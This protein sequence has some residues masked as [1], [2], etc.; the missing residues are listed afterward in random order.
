MGYIL[1][2][3]DELVELKN[4]DSINEQFKL[5]AII[6]HDPTDNNLK[7]HIRYH[8]LDLARFSG[9][10]FLFIT[11]IQ[12]P[13]EYTDA[14][15]RGEYKYAKLLVGDSG[16]Q[17]D[18]D[19]VIDPLIRKY[20]GLPEDGSYL[21][22]AKKLSDDEVFIAPT[23]TGSLPYQLMDLTSYSEGLYDFDELMSKLVNS[24]L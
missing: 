4:N 24:L 5:I 21:V 15:R 8:F 2:R 16:Q 12:P 9:E 7:K 6:V 11:F 3:F 20:Y 23:T 13:R 14:I 1:N 18:T 17:S 10:H 22:F 19:T